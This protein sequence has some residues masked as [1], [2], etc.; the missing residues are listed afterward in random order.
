MALLD[1]NVTIQ[2][3]ESDSFS[4]YYTKVKKKKEKKPKAFQLKKPRK[5]VGRLQVN[6]AVLS[7]KEV[8]KRSREPV[9]P[10]SFPFYSL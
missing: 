10:G 9:F 3:Q 7:V 6:E 5:E 2:D 8:L 4:Q 1:E